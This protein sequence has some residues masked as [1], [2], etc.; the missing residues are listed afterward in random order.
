MSRTPATLPTPHQLAGLGAVL[1]QFRA[2]SGGELGG[3]ARA[4]RAAVSIHVD[5]DCVRESLHFF[6]A[7][8]RPCWRLHLLPETDFLAWER[9]CE[10]LPVQQEVASAAGIALRLWRRIGERETWQLDAMRLHTVS[11]PPGMSSI[12]MLAASPAPLSTLG[13]ETARRIARQE[14]IEA[15]RAI[16]DCCCRHASRALHHNASPQVHY[17]VI[18]FKRGQLA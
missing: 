11:P 16:D 1:C 8:D 5:S 9:L 3:W 14:G 6:D 4:T 17:P 2:A 15:A 7:D 13:A 12:A 18:H 10:C